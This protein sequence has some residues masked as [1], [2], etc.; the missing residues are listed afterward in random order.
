MWSGSD[1]TAGDR[2]AGGGLT[3][4]DDQYRLSVTSI[5]VVMSGK[6]LDDVSGGPPSLPNHDERPGAGDELAPCPS[7]RNGSETVNRTRD[8]V[9]GG[10]SGLG[11][12]FRPR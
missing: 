2:P 12:R 11:E 1:R 7:P 4:T 5:V 9:S 10:R 6:P 8:E 3:W